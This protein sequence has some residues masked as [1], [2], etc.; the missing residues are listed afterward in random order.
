MGCLIKCRNEMWISKISLSFEEYY[1][2]CKNLKF[3]ALLIRIRCKKK[4]GLYIFFQENSQWYHVPKAEPFIFY[5]KKIGIIKILK[6]IIMKMQLIKFH[7]II[8]CNHLATKDPMCT[9]NQVYKY[10]ILFHYMWIT[11]MVSADTSFNQWPTNNF[12]TYRPDSKH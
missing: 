5:I 7:L 6:C 10:Q 11:I 1:W 2:H 3:S 12:A 8:S 4:G 9:M